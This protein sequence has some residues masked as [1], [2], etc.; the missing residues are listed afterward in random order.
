MD[1]T[2][3]V[4]LVTGATSGFGLR[5]CVALA[6]RGMRVFGSARDPARAQSLTSAAA[7]AGVQVELVRLD[8]TDRASIPRP[9]S[10]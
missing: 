2:G 7:E 3:R 5:A 6:R 4:A 10:T 1:V 8:V 9:G